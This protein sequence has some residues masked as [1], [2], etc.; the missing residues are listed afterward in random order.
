VILRGVHQ[1]P[2]MVVASG[3][4]LEIFLNLKQDTRHWGGDGL[5]FLQSGGTRTLIFFRFLELT[6]L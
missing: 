2:L 6:H 5:P 3:N 1:F 4:R